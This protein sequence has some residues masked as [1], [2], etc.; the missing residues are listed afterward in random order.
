MGQ[1][2]RWYFCE[3]NTEDM[4]FRVEEADGVVIEEEVAAA[5]VKKRRKKIRVGE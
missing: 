1:F 3:L 2:L 4:L 5:P